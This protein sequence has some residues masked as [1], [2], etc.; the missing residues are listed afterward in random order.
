MDVGK[1]YG[2]GIAFPPRIGPDGSVAFSA[3]ADNVRESIRLILMTDNERLFLPDFGAGLRRFLFEPNTVGTHRAIEDAITRSV[4]R[5]EPRVSLSSVEV[6]PA[7]GDPRA[8]LATL[9][10]VLVATRVAEQLAVRIPV[11]AGT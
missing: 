6:E 10:Y 9:R 4:A 11:A 7:A 3:G 2:R 5:W 1:I 8:A